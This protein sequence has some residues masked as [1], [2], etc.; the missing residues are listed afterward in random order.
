MTPGVIFHLGGKICLILLPRVT[1]KD[2]YVNIMIL[3][4]LVTIIHNILLLVNDKYFNTWLHCRIF[5]PFRYMITVSTIYFLYQDVIVYD[6]PTFYF[7]LN[8]LDK[9]GNVEA[10]GCTCSCTNPYKDL[11]DLYCT[12]SPKISSKKRNKMLNKTVARMKDIPNRLSITSTNGQQIRLVEYLSILLEHEW[13][14]TKI[15]YDTR[16]IDEDRTK[17]QKCT[18]FAVILDIFLT[19]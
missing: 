7:D 8:K 10:D 13:R 16:D 19:F 5:Y 17:S 15:K 11:K 3:S 6:I 18:C 12:Y 9:N 1:I 4:C 2:I 14:L